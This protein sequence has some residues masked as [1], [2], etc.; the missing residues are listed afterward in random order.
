MI[1]C[2]HAMKTFPIAQGFHLYY[3]IDWEFIVFANCICN[4]FELPLGQFLVTFLI[5]L[6][7]HIDPEIHCAKVDD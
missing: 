3:A 6:L 2:P 1:V 5:D 4:K 7:M